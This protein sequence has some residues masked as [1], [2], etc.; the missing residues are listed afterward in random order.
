MTPE[1]IAAKE[2]AD[3]TAGQN[4]E[5]E[6]V[7]KITE[8]GEKFGHS[9]LAR[10]ALTA[11]KSVDEFREMLLEAQN[12]REQKPLNEQSRQAEIGLTDKEARQ[13]SLMNVVRALTEP[14]DK[15][16]QEA[17]AFEF[18]ASRAAAEKAGRTTERFMIPA[19]VLTR[20]MNSTSG[21]ATNADTG[22]YS[23]Q[24]VLQTSSF[25]DILRNKGL[26]LNL[27]RTLG[28]L[29]GTIDIPKQTAAAQAY[30]I[31]EDDDAGE[32]GIGLGQITMS[33]K[34]LAA[35]SE[36]TRKLVN[37]SSMDIEAMLRYD[38][39]V[40]LGLAIDK[41]VLYG[42]GSDHQPLGITNQTGIHAVPFAAAGAP[43]FPELVSMETKIALDNADVDSMQY[44]A[45]AGFRGYAKTA[46]KFP[47]SSSAETIWEPGGTVNG[48]G[49][50]IT[51]QVNTGDV[52]F[53]NFADALIGMWG[54]L[55]MMVDPYSGSKKGRVRIVVFQDVDVAIRRTQSF[56]L[57]RNGVTAN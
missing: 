7:R 15:R 3:R 29:K 13:F 55:E 49:C 56:C 54:G 6:R 43:T 52:L 40:Q 53:G 16:A 23:I 8:I 4:A 36:V 44:V 42:I 50:G 22:G 25:I 39:A 21:G 27:C 18:E 28:G 14:T 37:Q 10:S 24:N 5:R 30:W 26:M 2:A 34:T 20:A 41:A 1:E 35:F 32:T 19:D 12:Q 38:L 48:Y 51:N 45:N 17:A 33:P 31:G 57:G 46:L 11:G 9:D 47:T